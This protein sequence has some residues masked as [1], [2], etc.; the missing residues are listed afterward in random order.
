M[1]ISQYKDLIK[2]TVDLLK[3][4]DTNSIYFDNSYFPELVKNRFPFILK[5]LFGVFLF[6]VADIAVMAV[7]VAFVS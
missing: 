5:K 6:L 1:P 7:L 4:L 2:D 3:N